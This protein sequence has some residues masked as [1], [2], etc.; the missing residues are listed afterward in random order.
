[1]ANR[2]R[3]GSRWILAV[4]A[5]SA[6]LFFLFPQ[7][8][9]RP[10]SLIEAPL[11]WVSAQFTRLA[12]GVGEGFGNFWDNYA[13]LRGVRQENRALI[14]EQGRLLAEL[15]TAR[16]S[17]GRAERLEA[18]LAFRKTSPPQTLAARVIGGDATHWFNSLLL[19][20]GS[21]AGIEPGDGVITPEGVVGRVVRTTHNTAQ[22][23]VVND[24][25]AVI[26]ARVAR[27]RHAGILVGGVRP[28]RANTGGDISH[29]H[30]AELKYVHRSADVEVG[31]RVVTSAL[32]G[33]FPPGVPIG[34]VSFVGRVAT[35]TFLTI[36]VT[37]LVRTDRLE[38]VLVVTGGVRPQDPEP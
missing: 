7:T 3:G 15:A 38:E 16:E 36:H 29:Q 21:F 37:P 23:L 33:R 14:E 31:D 11:V 35:E 30:E 25:S 1:M 9:T 2:R 28:G 6:V 10:L 27:S 8:R 34:T 26:P 5:V 24:R 20:Q 19:D 13:D 18:L 32:S 12:S 17:V 22:V 4:L